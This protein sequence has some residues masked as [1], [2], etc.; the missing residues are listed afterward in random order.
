MNKTMEEMEGMA[1]T[2]VMEEMVV[3]EGMAAMV[4]TAVMAATVD[5]IS[6]H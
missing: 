5:N 4:V 6:R 3:M 2:V 1:V